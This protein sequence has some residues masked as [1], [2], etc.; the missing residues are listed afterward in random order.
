MEVVAF[1]FQSRG[2]DDGGVGNTLGEGENGFVDFLPERQVGFEE[3]GAEFAGDEGEV[4][5]VEF[6]AE[7]GDHAGQAFGVD[8]G[9]FVVF[10]IG[11]ALVPEDAL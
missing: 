2:A 3:E 5:L 1:V 8:A 4:G 6:G 11:F 9:V 10:G 7:G